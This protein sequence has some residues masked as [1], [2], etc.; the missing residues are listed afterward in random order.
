MEKEGKQFQNNKLKKQL[1][2][3]FLF[4]S[5]ICQYFNDI[6]KDEKDVSAGMAAIR[7]LLKVLEYS[8]CKS[9]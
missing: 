7:T 6:I 5:E 2:F 3:Q 4:F 8:K 9:I 1:Y